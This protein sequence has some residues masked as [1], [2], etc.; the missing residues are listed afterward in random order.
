MKIL[1]II[2]HL[3]SGGAERF[4]VDLSNELAK[5]HDVTLMTVLDDKV[6]AEN[7]NFCRFALNENVKYVNLGLPNGLKLSSQLAALKSI[8]ALHPDIV[9]FHLACTVN[10]CALAAIVLSLKFKVYLTI[11]S[12][13][14][15]GYDKGLV[16][17]LCNT[18]G[19]WGRFK[20]IC[21]SEKNYADFLKFYGKSS[22]ARCI[23]NGRA[24]IVPTD[25]YEKVVAE[26]Q[27]YRS[28]NKSMLFLHVARFNPVK[29]QNLLIDSF[30]QLIKEG[31]DVNLVI[32]GNG[33]D[34]ED[35]LAL[36]RKADERIY[37]IGTRKNVA[38]YMLNADIFCL[39]SDFEGMPI[40]LLEASLAGI[41]AVST[42]VCGAVDLIKDN[43]NG[44]LSPGHSIGEYKATILRAT[45]QYNQLKENAYRM[46]EN[47]PYT[48]A[49]CANKYMKY[50][51]E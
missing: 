10:H 4:V 50:F 18:Y 32:I 15:N 49:E 38:D 40:T 8:N 36:Q 5:N 46:K 9:H 45:K 48:I 21:L 25:L 41:P 42:P 27:G 39:S 23:V 24:P 29:N 11:H 7:R 6:D 43:V 16:K 51:E 22:D 13:I 19:R 20:S 14:H 26:M 31:E 1:E 47:S 3:G 33:Y 37:F 28:S 2:T 35:G 12:D 34:S 30:N 44:C 17:L